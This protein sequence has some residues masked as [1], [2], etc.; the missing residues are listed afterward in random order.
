[1]PALTR[2]RRPF[3]RPCR[4][5]LSALSYHLG[6]YQVPAKRASTSWGCQDLP[7]TRPDLCR[8]PDRT[9]RVPRNLFTSLA[10]SF[11]LELQRSGDG[12]NLP[13]MR[14]REQ[15][16]RER[17]ANPR[18]VGLGS[19]ERITIALARAT[20]QRYVSPDDSPNWT[21][22]HGLSSHPLRP[23]SSNDDGRRPWSIPGAV[24]D[25]SGSN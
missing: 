1:M 14:G 3:V 9:H 15:I 22:D 25:G 13:H 10:S 18:R 4:P 5:E 24:R 11:T 17:E 21:E 12:K 16:A 6:C 19:R 8:D 7:S 23:M 20:A 2:I